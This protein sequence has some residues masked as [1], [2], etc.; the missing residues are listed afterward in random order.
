MTHCHATGVR[1]VALGTY[2]NEYAQYI[3]TLEEYSSQQ[4][5]G[6]STLFGP[7]TLEAYRQTAAGLARAIAQDSPIA[8][9]PAP[10]PWS[11]TPQ[12]RYR[13]R[14]HSNTDVKLSFYNADDSEQLLTLPNG[15]KTIAAGAEIAY[16]E[17][18]FTGPPPFPTIEKVTVWASDATQPTMAAGQLL[19]IASDGAITVG[20]Y[21]PPP[22]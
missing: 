18:E 7:H 9:G 16:P 10:N 6:A 15:E 14:N 1:H 2:A 3:T 8:P 5:E 22:H 11:A 12:R 13:F 20:N 17:R 4:Y 19:T 21:T